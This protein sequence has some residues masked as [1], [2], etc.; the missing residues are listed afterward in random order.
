[1]LGSDGVLRFGLGL[2]TSH[3][4]SLILEG[5]RSFLGLDHK[6]IGLRL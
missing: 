5:L 2:D 6:Y 1:M 4:P 3:F